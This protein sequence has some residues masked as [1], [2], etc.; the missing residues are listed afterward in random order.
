MPFTN[1]PHIVVAGYSLAMDTKVLDNAA[2]S[3]KTWSPTWQTSAFRANKRT[4]PTFNHHNHCLPPHHR[5]C[6]QD[7]GVFSDQ[8]AQT[9]PAPSQLQA[10]RDLLTE[11][12]P[13]RPPT[14][15]R[16]RF[17]T[18]P[19]KASTSRRRAERPGPGLGPA[20]QAPRVPARPLNRLPR[21]GSQAGAE[22]RGRGPS[23]TFDA[24]PVRGARGGRARQPPYG[25]VNR[26]APSAAGGTTARERGQPGCPDRRASA[27]RFFPRRQQPQPPPSSPAPSSAP[28]APRPSRE[29][30]GNPWLP[31]GRGTGAAR[32]P[33]CSSLLPSA[34]GSRRRR[35]RPPRRAEPSPAARPRS[36]PAAAAYPLYHLAARRRHTARASLPL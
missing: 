5:L 24:G 27:S 4:Y 18:A 21:A 34:P 25:P 15:A 19:P 14:P 3:S 32:R 7:L 35:R 17:S 6:S 16:R 26:P 12:A 33:P 36:L 28:A 29:Y 13:L 22:A 30:Y 20:G 11:A 23:R 10:C 31:R 1:H 2:H 9:P 8:K